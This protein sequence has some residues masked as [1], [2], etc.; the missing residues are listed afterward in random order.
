QYTYTFDKWSPEISEVS[1]DITYTATFSATRF[2]AKVGDKRFTTFS[3]AVTESEKTKGGAVITL[4]ADADAPCSMNSL[5][6]D[7]LRIK[8]SGYSADITNYNKKETNKGVTY[9]FRTDNKVYVDGTG[10]D[11]GIVEIAAAAA[12]TAIVVGTGVEVVLGAGASVVV[13]GAAASSVN[14][15]VSDSDSECLEEEELE[16][17]SKKY[18]N[19]KFH[20]VTIDTGISILDAASDVLPD[21]VN[22]IYA[23]YSQ[24]VATIVK[25][26]PPVLTVIGHTDIILKFP[27]P[28]GWYFPPI[29]YLPEAMNPGSHF[30]AFFEGTSYT[31]YGTPFIGKNITEDLEITGIWVPYEAAIIEE[32]GGRDY[33]LQFSEACEKRNDRIVEILSAPLFDYTLQKVSENPDVYEVLRVKRGKYMG[34]CVFAPPNLP[35][36]YYMKVWTYQDEEEGEITCYTITNEYTVKWVVN[37]V[38]VE[39]DED[40]VYGSMPE[41]NGETPASYF[42]GNYEYTFAGWSPE[43]SPVTKSVTYTATFTATQVDGYNLSLDDCIHLNLYINV[44]DYVD[45]QNAKLTVAHNDPDMQSPTP[46]TETY[47]G[48]ELISLKDAEDGRY[49]VKVLA[50]PAQLRD[51]MTVTLYNGE[52]Y[53][54]SFTV[55]VKDYCE[56]II[57]LYSN[58]EDEKEQ[59][60]VVLAKTILDYGKACSDEFDYNESEFASQDYIYSDPV[61]IDGFI[62]MEGPSGI[63]KSYTYVAKSIPSLRI[64]INKTE[65]QCVVEGLIATVTDANGN[66][67]EIAPTVVEGTTRVCL[68]IT[69]ILAENFDGINVIEYDGVTLRMNINQY[70]KAKGGDLGRSM[71]NYG[72]AAKNYFKN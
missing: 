3:E 32:D 37:G 57:N 50:A 59:Q 4:L 24:N 49:V 5:T 52:E 72:V 47:S 33:Y 71:F 7:V 36:G 60:L 11:D 58:S 26:L 67:R 28:E 34:E 66:V 56:A 63:L 64:N 19:H 31:T 14:V 2:I 65:A 48:E 15:D 22:D 13:E 46:I 62:Q 44:D 17:G 53:I 18:T 30:V 38:T 40:V 54:R 23:T 1:G 55:S 61:E 42:D 27:Y 41:Y 16:D 35:E 6:Y 39:T 12:A 20:W 69:G 8:H 10:D 21:C 29:P 25:I 68:D 51:E 70:A 9:Y 43:L 45:A